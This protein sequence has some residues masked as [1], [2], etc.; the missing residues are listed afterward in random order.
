MPK[1]RGGFRT[2]R[3]A[4]PARL[5]GDVGG[6]RVADLC[7]AP[8]GKTAQL[9]AAGA[10]VT[11]VDRA[12]A[13]L[14]RLAENLA[15]LS[16]TAELVCA[17]VAAWQAEPFDAVLLD[18][19]CSSTGTIRRHPDVPWL[20]RAADIATL[21]ALQ[22]RLLERA[23]ALIK[24]GGTLVYCTCSLE[25]E[26]NENIIADLLAREPGVRRAPIA[27]AEVFGRTEFITKDGDLRTLPCHL[28]DANSRFAGRRWLLCRAAG[29][30]VTYI[31][32]L[33]G[34]WPFCHRFVMV[35]RRGNS[36]P[37]RRK[38][39]SA[40]MSRVAVANH[41]KL[42][43]LLLRGAM[44]RIAGRANGH[45]LL[46]WPLPPLKADR[47]LI[48]PQDLRTADRDARERNL[49]RPFRLR[50]QGRGLRR[51]LDFRNGAAVRRMGG[52]AA[53]L[54]LAA[55]SARGRIRHHPR[56]CARAGRRMDRAARLL[57][58][59]RLAAGRA[60]APHHL[61]AQPVDAGSARRRC[62]LLPA[63][64]AQPVRQV[65]Y[66]RHTAGDARR[67]VARMQAVIA[68][69]YAALCIAGQARHIKSTTERLKHEIERQILPDGGH[70]SRDPGAI[71]EILLELLPLRQAFAAR[72]IAPPQALLNA[73]DRMMPMLRFFRH[74]EGTF[75]HFNGMGATP[76]DLVLDA[77]RLRRNARRAVLERALF[78]AISGSKPAAA[79]SSWIPAARR[80]SR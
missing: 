25:P 53:G 71:I 5:I 45:P 19:P 80:R 41:A 57:A 79:W 23:V 67:G 62:A 17:D 31:N 48:A 29:K 68:L 66:L 24:P 64:P 58:S 77:A 32:S 14:K 46:R 73:I 63:L 52:G 6:R 22:R 72:N 35:R 10:A 18:A 9:A 50:R 65:R 11:A 21:A 28:P 76:A 74:S 56:Q 78:R 44:R 27:A 39:R 47:L 30:I 12:P 75:A 16:L 1:A 13:R 34:S 15:R 60:V 4:L 7:A 38:G 36:A 70:V 40:S 37:A 2:P 49:F 61:L 20:K 33:F 69:S 3:A 59:D 42:S 43:W 26:E 55:P 54:R 8:G 51:P